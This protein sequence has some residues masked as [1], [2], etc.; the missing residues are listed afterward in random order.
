MCPGIRHTDPAVVV[1]HIRMGDG[2]MLSRFCHNA[3]AEQ[4]GKKLSGFMVSDKNWDI[5]M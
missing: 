4:P 5:I 2:K 1:I 3:Q